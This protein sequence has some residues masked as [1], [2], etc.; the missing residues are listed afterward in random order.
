MIK[1]ELTV[2]DDTPYFK[3][4]TIEEVDDYVH[5]WM[6]H[7]Y[8]DEKLRYCVVEVANQFK[9]RIENGDSICCLE[10]QEVELNMALAEAEVFEALDPI[11]FKIIE[12]GKKEDPDV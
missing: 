2:T 6:E 12:G 5:H 8:Y 10:I 3:L 11:P 7:F 1:Y 9:Q 4:T